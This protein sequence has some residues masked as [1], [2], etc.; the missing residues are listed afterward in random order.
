MNYFPTLHAH[1]RVPRGHMLPGRAEPATSSTHKERLFS[2]F[3]QRTDTSVHRCLY[4]H[5]SRRTGAAKQSTKRRTASERPGNTVSVYYRHDAMAAPFGRRDDG[6]ESELDP[7]HSHQAVHRPKENAPTSWTG[8][9]VP[10]EYDSQ[11]WG[12]GGQS[13]KDN[14]QE[15][16]TIHGDIDNATVSASR[17]SCTADRI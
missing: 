1:I 8:V 4:R 7:T 11:D 2:R 5:H 17:T 14:E 13:R 15:E 9:T 16:G 12:R 10:A 6:I 3:F